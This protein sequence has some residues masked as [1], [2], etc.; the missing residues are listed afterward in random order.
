MSKKFLLLFFAMVIAVLSV[1][2]AFASGEKLCDGT[3]DGCQHD[4]EP[5][6]PEDRNQ[7]YYYHYEPFGPNGMRYYWIDLSKL[8]G[9]TEEPAAETVSVVEETV[10]PEEF[11]LDKEYGEFDFS[12]LENEKFCFSGDC[13]EETTA[14]IIC[15]KTPAAEEPSEKEMTAEEG[16]EEEAHQSGEAINIDKVIRILEILKDMPGDFDVS[17][18]IMG[19][20]LVDFYIDKYSDTY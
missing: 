1:V 5:A 19:G 18:N 6:K 3:H 12:S 10:K 11:D 8:Y 13:G 14:E 17:I 4:A 15:E 20:E 9:N 7:Y 16:A 2:P